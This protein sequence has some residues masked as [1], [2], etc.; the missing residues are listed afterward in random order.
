MAQG[1][2]YSIS[3]PKLKWTGEIKDQERSV[4][5]GGRKEAFIEANAAV[6]V[7]GFHCMQTLTTN[8]CAGVNSPGLLHS[9]WSLC[10][11]HLLILVEIYL[12]CSQFN[13]LPLSS[14]NQKLNAFDAFCILDNV[15]LIH[16]MPP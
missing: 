9:L 15:I 16:D 3:S 13:S 5:P 11:M 4:S 6:R 10:V 2:G 1:S 7:V 12:P 8:S 14:Y